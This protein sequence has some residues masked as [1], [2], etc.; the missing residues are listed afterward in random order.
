MYYVNVVWKTKRE[1][2]YGNFVVLSN[3]C[4]KRETRAFKSHATQVFLDNSLFASFVAKFLLFSHQRIVCTKWIWNGEL[5]VHIEFYY[6]FGCCAKHA[7][8][9]IHS[10]FLLIKFKKKNWTTLGKID[11]IFTRIIGFFFFLIFTKQALGYIAINRPVEQ[12]WSTIL[13]R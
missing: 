5:Y 8:K 7:A 4:W 11:L 1:K 9:L 6:D 10:H 3:G 13:L 2:N 12:F